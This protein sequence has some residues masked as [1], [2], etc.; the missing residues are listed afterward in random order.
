MK[1]LLD[2]NLSKRLLGMLDEAFPGSAHV[3]EAGL[4]RASDE[5]I[6]EYAKLH[7]FVIVSKDSDFHQRSLLYGPPPQ[8]IWIRRGNCSTNEIGELLRLRKNEIKAA[9]ADPQAAFIELD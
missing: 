3:S 1:L 5:A 4:E 8:V 6:W 9:H 7:G 2:E